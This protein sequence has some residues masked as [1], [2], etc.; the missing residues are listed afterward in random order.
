M[1]RKHEKPTSAKLLFPC[2]TPSQLQISRICRS[3]LLFALSLLVLHPASFGLGQEGYVETVAHPRS[4]AIAQSGVAASIYVDAG[5]YPGVVRAAHDLQSDIARVTGDTSKVGFTKSGLGS[6][7]I[8]IGTIGKSPVID[9]LIRCR[10]INVSYISNKWESFLIQVVPK[11]LPGVASALVIA[12]SDKRGTIYGI[13][14]V[15]EQ[16]GVSPWYWWRTFPSRTK[17]FCL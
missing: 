4:F 7:V 17:T 12:G 9:Q 1:L 10:K 13:Y 16:I 2:M 11:P 14:D 15:S 3:V 6:N 5:D 8:I